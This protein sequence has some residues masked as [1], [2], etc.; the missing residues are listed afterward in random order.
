VRTGVWWGNLGTGNHFEDLDV[1]G[2]MILK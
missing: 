1:D 2:R